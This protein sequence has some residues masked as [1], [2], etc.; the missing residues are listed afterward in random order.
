MAHNEGGSSKSNKETNH[1]QGGG[2]VHDTS[3]C[4]G[5]RGE[6]EDESHGN[7]GSI[8]I[9]KRSV[10]ETK[11]DS[12]GDRA[13]VRSPNILLGNAKGFLHLGQKRSDGEPNKE[14]DEEAEPGA[15]E[16][17]HVRA[18]EGEELDFRGFVILVGIDSEVVGRVLLDFWSLRI[19]VAMDD[20]Q[21]F[22]EI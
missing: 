1:G 9:T 3:E 5:N 13:N 16:G 12:S 10:D 6:G 8:L 21:L 2:T 19:I 15:V 14:S 4:A 11:E 20:V 18:G 7:T 17:T 22:C